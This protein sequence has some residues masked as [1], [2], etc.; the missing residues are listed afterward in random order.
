[1][2]IWTK[3]RLLAR[4]AWALHRMGRQRPG[5]ETD[6]AEAKP[7]A[8]SKL[9][10]GVAIAAIGTVAGIVGTAVQNGVPIPWWQVIAAVGAALGIVG[11][12]QKLDR[13]AQPK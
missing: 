10:W 4:V 5:R 1:M 6:M 13:M 8:K 7:L 2:R 12:G 9:N 3:V 11:G